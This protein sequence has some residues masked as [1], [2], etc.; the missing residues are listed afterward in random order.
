MANEFVITDIVDKQAFDQLD[1]LAQKFGAV[2]Q[3]FVE[4]TTTIGKG[5]PMPVG[6]LDE[7]NKKV[8]EFNQQGE[9]LAKVQKE[10]ADLQA[11][12]EALL[13]KVNKGIEERTK[14][15]KTEASY[16]QQLANAMRTSKRNASRGNQFGDQW[17]R[18]QERQRQQP[19][20]QNQR[21]Q[22][23]P[24]IQ[25]RQNQRVQPDPNDP[26]SIKPYQDGIRNL[27]NEMKGKSYD[28]LQ[29]NSLEYGKKMLN[30]M[31]PLVA[32]KLVYNDDVLRNDPNYRTKPE[33][34]EKEKQ[35]KMALA[36]GMNE[37]FNTMIRSLTS[38]DFAIKLG[39]LASM[40]DAKNCMNMIASLPKSPLH[41]TAPKQNLNMNLNLSSSL[42]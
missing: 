41:R 5:I 15:I 13:Q 33:Y 34:A 11:K 28:E 32:K 4:I 36:S 14:A 20:M 38:P 35:T 3:Q 23:N 1:E 27:V 21:F 17:E 10:M 31:I 42:H 2:K 18:E 40:G 29:A 37:K 7:Y 26:A 16:E 39:K 24:N 9:Q 8:Q 30:L 19:E 6:T 25:Q 22:S 12:Y